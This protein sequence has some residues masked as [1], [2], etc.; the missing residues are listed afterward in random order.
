LI[1]GL[2]YDLKEAV[3]LGRDCPDDALEEYDSQETVDAIAR[4]LEAQGHSVV[5]LGGG[6]EFLSN[7]LHGRVDFVF[8]IAEGLGNL[9]S[10]EAQVPSILEMLDIPYSGSDPQCLA[11]CL[12]KPLTKKLV[13]AAGVTTPRWRVFADACQLAEA[14]WDGF[15]F[16][17][18]VKPSH[19]GSSKGISCHR[20]ENATEATGL[21][22]EI[23]SRYRQPVMVEEFIAGDEVTVGVIGNS[24]PAV[25]GAMRIVPRRQEP[26]FVYSIEVKRDW[27]NLVDYECPARLEPHVLQAVS[28]ASLSAFEVLGC[29]DVARIDF[30]ISPE[31]VPYFLEVNPLPGLNPH[32]GDL[33]IMAS[34]LGLAYEALIAAIFAAASER[35]AGCRA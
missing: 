8:N 25:L 32:T 4:A 18:F 26:Y 21:A 2:S 13:A 12:D 29:R 27:E 33:P 7:I 17:A 19:E 6:T 23:L 20:A 22:A 10:R 28:E 5:G 31:G 1:V 3:P 14:V 11:I 35:C 30:R 24:P 9:R 34:R 15:P 16:P